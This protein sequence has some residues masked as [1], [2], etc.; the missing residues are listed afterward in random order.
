MSAHLAYSISVLWLRAFTSIF[1]VNLNLSVFQKQG[2]IEH[3]VLFEVQTELVDRKG[4][5]VPMT[6]SY[7][8]VG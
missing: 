6:G 5:M 2:V 1:L 3:G 4:N 7:W 8:I